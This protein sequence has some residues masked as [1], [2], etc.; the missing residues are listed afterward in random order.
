MGTNNNSSS[1][2][3]TPILLLVFNRPDT[4]TQVF[5]KI[6]QIKPERLYIASDGPREGNNNDKERIVKVR[7]IVT[8]VNWPCKVE[9][10]FR[11]QNLGCKKGVSTAINWF[12]ENEEQGII[13]EDDCVPN[14]DFF[15]FCEN[16]LN[17]YAKD[18]RVLAITGNNFQNGKLRG[19]SSYYFSKYNHCWGWSTWRRSWKKY[20]GEINFWPKWKNSND[21]Y[22]FNSDKVERKYWK[23][24][25][26]SVYMKK[27]DSWA[28]PWQAC[29][30]Y[31]NGLTAT[32]NVN[33][34][35]N[36]GFGE[37]ATHT[38]YKNSK[39]S[40][41]PV[42]TLSNFKHPTNVKRD[43]AADRWTFDYHFGGKNLRFPFNW[44]S[45]PSRI[46]RL[47]NRKIKSLL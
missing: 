33:L 29:A 43:F 6:S 5:E 35:S 20:D 10:L 22:N 13:L 12:F 18:E 1:F 21:W 26:D 4:V 41:M 11:D 16:L 3:K 7:N 24:I 19:E 27:I 47:V 34:V 39:F 15:A 44:I 32:P 9:T 14:L 23:N 40:K 37:Q 42:K 25:L 8:K 46:I 30:W 17:L 36:I 31:S 2:L 38:K 45:L 28:Y